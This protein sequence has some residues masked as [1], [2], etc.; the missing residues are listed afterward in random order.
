[1]PRDG[2][3]RLLEIGCGSGVYVRRAA[4]RNPRLTA[5]ALELQP[6]VAQIARENLGSW[7]LAE[8]ATVETG[9]V[10]DRTPDGSFDLATLHN[11]IY[12]FR[13][14][15][16]VALLRHALG[17]LKPGGKLLLTTGCR[18]GSAAMGILSLWGGLTEGA[19]RLPEVAE[20]EGQLREAGFRS[21]TSRRILPGEAM[22]AFV[23]VC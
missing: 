4:Q 23:A 21:A 15:E 12:Y 1:M 11:N 16:R 17:F 8:R 5:L 2:A 19:G 7:G 18:G 9:D 10:R 3:P 20:L 22:F 14:G 13:V 6:R